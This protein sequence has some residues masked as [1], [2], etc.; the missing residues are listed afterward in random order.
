MKIF[1]KSSVAVGVAVAVA[2]ADASAAFFHASSDL[3]PGFAS[4]CVCAVR[5]QP[6]KFQYINKTVTTSSNVNVQAQGKGKLKFGGNQKIDENSKVK[7]KVKKTAKAKPKRGRFPLDLRFR[8]R[9]GSQS[10]V[11]K[12]HALLC[13]WF[14]HDGW[15]CECARQ[16]EPWIPA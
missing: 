12:N 9:P 1:A 3:I 7:E 11:K 13:R 4:G 15:H 14:L 8:P 5:M 16:S 10:L 6:N 2:T